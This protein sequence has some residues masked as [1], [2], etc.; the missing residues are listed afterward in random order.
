[1]QVQELIR[2]PAAVPIADFHTRN[3]ETISCQGVGSIEFMDDSYNGEIVT[4][5]WIFEGG[6]PQ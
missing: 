2:T 5:K 1:M 4:R 6:S 3:L